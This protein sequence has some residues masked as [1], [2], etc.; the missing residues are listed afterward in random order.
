MPNSIEKKAEELEEWG[1]DIMTG[2]WISTED[3]IEA[4]KQS[5]SDLLKKVMGVVEGH[6][7]AETEDVPEPMRSMRY[8]RNDIRES[9]LEKLQTLAKDEG[10]SID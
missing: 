4:S 5:S 8:G 1:G 9:I 7:V 10:V 2:W 6:K 3:F